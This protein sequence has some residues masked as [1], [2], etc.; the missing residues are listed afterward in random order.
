MNIKLLL[1]LIIFSQVSF[2]G[3]SQTNATASHTVS[4]VIKNQELGQ[5]Q[6]NYTNSKFG[7]SVT[8]P[9]WWDIKETP[10]PNFFGGTFPEINKSKSALLFKAFEKE[11]FKTFQNFENWVIS[12]YKS[13]DTPK[14]SKDH[15]I[16]YKKNLN[17]FAT[18]GKAFKVQIKADD[19]FYNSCYI[20]I[21]TSKSYI[22]ID[23]T[24]TRETYD[25]N[26]KDLEKIMSQFKAL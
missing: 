22:W 6:I 24:A 25:A 5:D 21:E 3:F 13:G 14:W 16:L 15:Q 2:N 26:F 23:L 7:Y 20:I 17:E 11:K 12:G 19:T 9:K 4:E 8:I 1:A 10:S 18:I